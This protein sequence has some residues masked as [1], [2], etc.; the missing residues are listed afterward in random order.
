MHPI[1]VPRGYRAQQGDSPRALALYCLALFAALMV[2][3]GALRKW[4]LPEYERLIYLAKDA[5]LVVFFV[6]LASLRVRPRPGTTLGAPHYARVSFIVLL[7]WIVAQSINPTIPNWQ[8]AVWGLKSHLLYAL[9]VMYVLIA[10]E[11]T[12][13]F[14]DRLERCYPYFAIPVCLLALAQV[15]LPG[16]HFL[17]VQVREEAVGATFGREG[18]VRVSGT[19]SYIAGMA[20]FEMIMFNVGLI[21]LLRGVRS[22]LFLFSLFLVVAALPATGTR[23]VIATCALAFVVTGVGGFAARLIPLSTFIRGVVV[24][25]VLVALSVVFQP[26]TW[27]A[28]IQRATA[29]DDTEQRLA[30]AFTNAFDFFDD[31]GLFGFGVG[32]A[33]L[34]ALALVP[35]SLPYAWL[36]IDNV[37]LEEESGRLVVELGIVGWLLYMLFRLALVVWAVKLLLRGG[38]RPVR[39]AALMSLPLL[40]LGVYIGTG[41]FTTPIAYASYWL[42]IAGLVLAQREDTALRRRHDAALRR[43]I[44]MPAPRGR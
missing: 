7:I 33:T 24:S 11:R 32:S 20:L 5:V 31:A 12:D 14:F 37:F 22:R 30:R 23:S 28:L 43:S 40:M 39:L 19:F 35:D 26:D 25:I 4:I 44:V 34:G 16:D 9:I 10:C 38:S 41:V 17:N 13:E 6:L 27:Q 21:L 18:L 15:A 42:V 36:P 8:V 2:Y 3:D 29:V 1:P